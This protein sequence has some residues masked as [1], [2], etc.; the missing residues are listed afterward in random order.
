MESTTNLRAPSIDE[1]SEEGVVTAPPSC[2]TLAS[3]EARHPSPNPE[4]DREVANY[5][6]GWPLHALT[7]A[8]VFAVS[9][10]KRSLADW[11]T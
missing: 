7:L 9:L 8:L 10:D 11:C 2:Q 3:L 5:L 6:Q 4:A 1:K